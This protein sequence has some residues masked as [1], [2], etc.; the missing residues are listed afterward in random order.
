MNVFFRLL[1]LLAGVLLACHGHA[2]ELLCSVKIDAAQIQGDKTIFQDMEG[3]IGRYLNLT[4]F[5]SDT[6]QPNERIRCNLQIVVNSRP[7]NDRFMCTASIQAFRPALNSN[8]ETM[9][10]NLQD[11]NFNFNYVIG[12]QLLYNENNY[13]N[14]LTSLLNFY[15]LLIIGMDMD[16]YA[17]NGGAEI[18]QKAQQVVTITQD[19]G[20][21]GWRG[22]EQS[23]RNRY[24]LN[25]NL[26]NQAYK[27]FHEALYKYHRQGID[28]LS[29]NVANG[30]RSIF[31]AVKL[32]QQLNKTR[33]QLLVVQAF[34]DAKDGE[35]GLVFEQ[36]FI[37]D[38]KDFLKIAEEMM[39][40]S[41]NKFEK[42]RSSQ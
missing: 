42:L 20:E 35:L 28:Q 6:Y 11:R 40:G 26:N 23:I 21:T 7:D 41:M 32:V 19:N 31:E 14:N 25:E 12:E 29:A 13:I 16:T 39:P 24:W 27:L 30:R 34:I 22:N 1:A 33:S 9:V 36:A 10:T 38:K 5:T 37:N 3:N 17:L 8:Y 2:Q 18:F 4:A 15:A